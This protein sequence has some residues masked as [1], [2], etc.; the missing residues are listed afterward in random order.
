MNEFT[1][2]SIFAGFGFG[3]SL[4]ALFISLETFLREKP[5]LK[6]EVTKCEHNAGAFWATLQI[7]NQGD[8][9]TRVSNVGLSFMVGTKIFRFK[10]TEIR[11]SHG[12]IYK[13]EPIWLE[14]HDIKE[15]KAYF[16]DDFEGIAKEKI[17]CIITIYHTHEPVDVKAVSQITERMI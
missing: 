12:D 14:A 10:A 13:S 17:D 1:I 8:R 7:R 9:G 4:F 16:K 11:E 2:T 6:I 15:L 3:I 5:R